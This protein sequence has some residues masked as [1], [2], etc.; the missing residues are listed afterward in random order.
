M[1]TELRVGYRRV[2]VTHPDKVL[3]P[4]AGLTKLDLARHYERVAPAMLP[5][6]RDR[7]LAMR[8]YPGGID[9]PGFFIKATPRHFP[10]WIDRVEVPKK[11]GTVTQVVVG[12]AATLVYL[13]AQNVVEPHVF[14]SRADMPDR[15]DRLIVDLDPSHERFA[16]VRAA[17]RAVGDRLRGVG[18][19]PYAMTSGSRGIHV[20]APLRRGPSFPEVHRLARALA[21]EM[22]AE[23]PD[24]LT[25][26]WHTAERGERIYLDVNRNAYAQHAIAAYGVRARPNAPVATPLHWEELSDPGLRPDGWTITTIGARLDEADPWLGMYRHARRLPDASRR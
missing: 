1:T 18:L 25:L 26:E 13:A 19:C 3:F 24:E 5:H 9:R 16:E 22:V 8:S 14:P 2:E 11:G 6:V 4:A 15:P 21:E 10:D 7:P 20:V 23:N 12:E 17:A